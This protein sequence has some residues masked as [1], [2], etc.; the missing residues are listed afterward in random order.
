MK[1][2]LLRLMHKVIKSL[3]SQEK[4][5]TSTLARHMESKTFTVII[6]YRIFIFFFKLL[7]LILREEKCEC[8]L[9]FASKK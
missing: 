4:V 6:Y 1:S 8:K 9:N 3:K 2:S 5:P 7:K